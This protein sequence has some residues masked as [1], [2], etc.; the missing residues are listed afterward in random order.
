MFALVCVQAFDAF[1]ALVWAHGENA[2]CALD[3][4]MFLAL[5]AAGNHRDRK[6]RVAADRAVQAC[7]ESLPNAQV[8]KA[9]LSAARRIAFISERTYA[10]GELAKLA[11]E[12]SGADF[13]TIVR[14]ALEW[15]DEAL[16]EKLYELRPE[17]VS[18]TVSS[19]ADS[20]TADADD[21]QQKPDTLVVGEDEARGAFNQEEEL[22]TVDLAQAISDLA[23][24]LTDGNADQR[25]H[26]VDELVS[27]RLS[28]TA[29]DIL[30]VKLNPAQLRLIEIF[31]KRRKCTA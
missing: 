31:E 14:T 26:A 1:G 12:S 24:A 7:F 13:E 21:C 30:A 29:N 6:C 28:G 27:I 16:G 20:E 18:R 4:L 2:T 23:K 3:K 19:L 10:S 8:I 15:K 17:A 9:V 5:H 25:K 22:T 11:E